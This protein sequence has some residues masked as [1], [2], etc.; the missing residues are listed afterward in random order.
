MPPARHTHA[1][2]SDRAE[3][4]ARSTHRSRP[5]EVTG[6]LPMS[7]VRWNRKVRVV[8]I[9]V[10]LLVGWMAVDAASAVISAHS[11]ANAELQTV[12]KYAQENHR[13]EREATQLTQRAFIIKAARE[14]GMVSKGEQPY[15]VNGL[16]P[17]GH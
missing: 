17:E 7:K 10:F 8:M 6:R 16:K 13:L 5:R 9:L 1:A 2:R 12:Q 4:Q 15:V 14:L 11:Q 3:P